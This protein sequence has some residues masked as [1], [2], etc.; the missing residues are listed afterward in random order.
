MDDSVSI[1]DI[2]ASSQ[3]DIDSGGIDFD[4]VSFVEVFVE[5]GDSSD[6][7][8]LGMSYTIRFENDQSIL[9]D[10]TWENPAYVSAN[11][12]EDVL[13]IRF[14]GP[15]YDKQDGLDIEFD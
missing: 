7:S 1:N 5:P 11:Q 12:P 4:R 14:N 3:V 13:V 8:K 15:I 2:S 6:V 10:I 9:I